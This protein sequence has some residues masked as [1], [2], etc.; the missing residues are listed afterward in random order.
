MTNPEV[1]LGLIVSVLDVATDSDIHYLDRQTGQI[2]TVSDAFDDDDA[3]D[4]TALMVEDMPERFAAL[5][6]TE[7]TGRIRALFA[8]AE[9]DE[10]RRQR[11]LAAAR[12]LYA[13]AEFPEALEALG[14]TE[15]W[16]AFREQE[17][18]RIAEEWAEVH[19]ITLARREMQD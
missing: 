6:G 5:P 4:L 14:L 10:D 11:L 8:L 3:D 17:L 13:H 7:Q 16:T 9:A 15:A 1:Q 2:V 18:T 12:H 19:G